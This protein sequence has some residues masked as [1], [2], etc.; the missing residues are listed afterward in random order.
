MPKQYDD[1]LTIPLFIVIELVV[2]VI[3]DA[4]LKFFGVEEPLRGYL[5][6]GTFIILLG[7]LLLFIYLFVKTP[8]EKN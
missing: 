5:A 8:D 4:A 6:S 1:P 3:S 7:I 2:Y